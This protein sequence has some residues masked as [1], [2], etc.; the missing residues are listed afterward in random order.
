MKKKIFVNDHWPIHK[1]SETDYINTDLLFNKSYSVI[2]IF[3]G[4]GSHSRSEPGVF[5]LGAR[6]AFKKR[7]A[8]AAW[9][10]KSGAGAGAGKN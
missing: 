1:T 6:A 7:G 10:K 5:G 3:A 8:G 4:L 2:Y 9:K